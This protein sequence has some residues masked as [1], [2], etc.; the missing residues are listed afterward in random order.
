[1]QD[2]YCLSAFHEKGYEYIIDTLECGKEGRSENG[3]DC[4]HD[5]GHELIQEK[6]KKLGQ[7]V[8]GT[9]LEW[10]QRTV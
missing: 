1:M 10:P 5:L 7:K 3:K 4:M 2:I 6:E 9:P 8:S